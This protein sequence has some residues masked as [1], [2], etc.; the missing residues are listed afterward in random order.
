MTLCIHLMYLY[1]TV[2]SLYQNYILFV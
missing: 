2:L 1:L